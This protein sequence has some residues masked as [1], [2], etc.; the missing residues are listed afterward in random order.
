MSYPPTAPPG[1]P[2]ILGDI[3]TKIR[4]VTKSPSQNQITDEQI[5]QYINTY[6][7]YD[8]PQELRLKDMFSNWVFNTVPNQECYPLPTDTVITVEPPVYI[9]GYQCSFTQSQE[10]FYM[11]Y[12]KLGITNNVVSGTGAST[13]A[14]NLNNFP[15]FQNNF[16]IGAI[17]STGAPASAMDTPFSN[18]IGSLAGPGVV[19]NPAYPTAPTSYVNYITGAVVINFTNTIPLGNQITTN[20]V[21]YNASRPVACL[22]YYNNLYLRPVPDSFYQVKV[23]AYI[24]P[25]ACLLGASNNPPTLGQTNDPGVGFVNDTDTPQL[26]QWWQLVAWGAALKVFEDRGDLENIQR[27]MPMYDMQRRL[28]LRRTLVE[29]SNERVSTPYS[30][31]YAFSM[32]SYFNQF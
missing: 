10:M 24:N 12:P 19:A 1:L 32:S 15:I 8:L 20:V 7:L 25:L 18:T 9:D 29:M 2:N 21:P 16:V 6:L 17:D 11:L 23:A 3:V 30:D 5:V 28:A 4:R 13:Y 26:K 31:Q 27:I 14:F 22:F